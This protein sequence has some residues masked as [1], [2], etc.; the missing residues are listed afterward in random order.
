MKIEQLKKGDYFIFPNKKTVYVYCG[1]C[2]INRRYE[3]YKFEDVSA[4]GYKSKGTSVSVD[5]IF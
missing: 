1:Y 2:R 3:Y 4:F 5:F